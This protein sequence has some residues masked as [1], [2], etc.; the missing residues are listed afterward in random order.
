M[1]PAG[2]TVSEASTMSE[3]T[4]QT[5]SI[6]SHHLYYLAREDREKAYCD[7]HAVPRYVN[8]TP[9]L[10]QESLIMLKAR[11]AGIIEKDA[12]Q[13]AELTNPNYV[14]HPDFLLKFLRGEHFDPTNAAEKVVKHF[15][16]KFD[17]FGA[18]CLAKDI[19]QKDL[20]PED[21]NA[22][23]SGCLQLLSMKDKN[24]RLN[25]V[26]FPGKKAMETSVMSQVRLKLPL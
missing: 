25:F 9:E 17:L 22:M 14:H 2:M 11:I 15:Q 3:M 19:H 23:Y 12:Y 24:G 8:E 21:I 26:L 20:E 6:I 5:E 13:L 7:L 4:S 16:L 10:L 18:S 1:I